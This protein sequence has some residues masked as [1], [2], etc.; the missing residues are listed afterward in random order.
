MLNTTKESI[1]GLNM[2]DSKKTEKNTCTSFSVI[3]GRSETQLA[4]KLNL[5]CKKAGSNTFFFLIYIEV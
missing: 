3:E 5:S 4:G 2:L 1:K